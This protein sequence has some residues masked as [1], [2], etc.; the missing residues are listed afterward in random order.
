MLRV[1]TAVKSMGS[2][3]DRARRHTDAELKGLLDF[4]GYPAGM[5]ETVLKL[6]LPMIF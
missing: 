5:E 3:G 1:L 6:R 2:R 4:V